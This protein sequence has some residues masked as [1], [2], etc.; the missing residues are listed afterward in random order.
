[1]NPAARGV[2]ANPFPGKSGRP[3]PPPFP[4]QHAASSLSSAASSSGWNPHA[5]AV[6]LPTSAP[7]PPP[8]PTNP[9]ARGRLPS[10]HRLSLL[11]P[12][13]RRTWPRD[14]PP[15]VDAAA[16]SA[17]ESQRPGWMQQPLR[18][19]CWRRPSPPLPASSPFFKRGCRRGNRWRRSKGKHKQISSLTT[20]IMDMCI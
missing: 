4:P 1:V 16:P 5:V 15:A 13:P 8:S 10:P 9:A 14:G 20:A 7:P 17:Q 19:A 11:G 3:R 2:P 6:F 12:P 18:V